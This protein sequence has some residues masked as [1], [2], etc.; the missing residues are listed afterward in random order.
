MTAPGKAPSDEGVIKDSAPGAAGCADNAKPW[1]LAATILGSS[2]AFIDGSVISVALPAIQADLAAPIRDAQWIVNAYTLLLGAL[3]LV[4]GAAGDRFGRRRVFATGIVL[5]TIASL[6]CAVAPNALILI[7]ARALQGVGGALLVPGSLAIISAAFPEAERGRAIGTWA[8][9]SALTT[10]LGPVLGGWMVDDLSWRAIFVI[11]APLAIIVLAITAWRVPE[12]HGGGGD[13]SIDW[14]GGALATFGLGALTYGMTE[15]SE[16]GWTHP[17]V[18][19]SMSAGAAILAV[20]LRVEA[21]A[22]EPMMPL[23]LFRS[24]TFSGANAITLLL[25]FALSGA[26]FFLPFQLIQLEGYSAT[27]AGAAFVPFTLIMGGLSRWSGGLCE[28]YG[29]RGPLIIGPIIVAAGFALLAIPDV[30]AAYWGVGYWTTYLPAMIVLGFGM[31]ASVAPLT[32][33][34]MGSIED[35]YAGTASGI[36]NAISRIAG[37]LA[38]ALLGALAVG[39]F[40]HQL[41]RHLDAQSV[42]PDIRRT[43]EAEVP[44]LGDARVPPDISGD[45]RRT[46]ENALKASLWTSFRITMLITA[47]L[48]LLSAACA[49]LTIASKPRRS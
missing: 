41:D 35:R 42:A 17:L 12:S 7:A 16:L 19:V 18:L 25:Y 40:G 5:F 30:L 49:A 43:I 11:N 24:T 20:F 44:K 38:V 26:F 10:A 14:L 23:H 8:G 21:K 13:T 28:R 39:M 27:E 15:T 4:G 1:V 45:V 9:F 34:V 6:L 37:L 46:V 22:R 31:A 2:M 33:A 29:A 32:T 3:I 36:N 47:V 48:A